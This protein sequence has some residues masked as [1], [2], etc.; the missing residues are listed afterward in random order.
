MI[1]LKDHGLVTIITVNYN[2]ASVTCDL[3]NSLSKISYKN[4]EII[5]VDNGS[6]EDFSI[7][8]SKY[9]GINLISSE[10]NLGFAGGNNLGLNQAKGKYILFI[11]NDVEVKP[12][13]LE[14]L[15]EK[16]VICENIAGVSPKIKYFSPGNI[17]QY[18]GSNPVNPFT[19]RNK[20][21]GTGKLDNGQFNKTKITSYLHGACMLV[22]KSTIDIIGKM[23]EQFF[24]YY[25]E[26]DWSERMNRFGFKIFYVPKSEV[27]HKESIS[28]GK[29]SAL[30]TYYL[31]RNRILFARKNFKG[32]K[33]LIS[34]IYL[35][36]ISLPKNTITLLREKEKLMAYYAGIIWN[37][38]NKS[39]KNN[40]VNCY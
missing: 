32:V 2:Q 30:K 17:I 31:S 12:N 6:M 5:V 14:P 20:H 22:K 29:N 13:F 39:T 10:K 35:A 9:P 7:I 27:F 15:L 8:K 38:K 11:N 28:T 25:E 40:T 16:I 36:L 34:M 23:D 37:L 33:F 19:L 3:L 26:Q 18:A 1:E 21:I 4:V 24:L